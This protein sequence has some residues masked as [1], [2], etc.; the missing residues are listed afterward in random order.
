MQRTGA[1]EV[2]KESQ[3]GYAPADEQLRDR[4]FLFIDQVHAELD[5]DLEMVTSLL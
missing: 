3:Y 4:Q 1:K 2:N 5:P